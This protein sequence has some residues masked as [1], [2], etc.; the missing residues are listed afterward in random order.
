MKNPL[1][2]AVGKAVSKRRTSVTATTTPA[3]TTVVAH[4]A[5]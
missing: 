3:V 1:S 4:G 2:K 5:V